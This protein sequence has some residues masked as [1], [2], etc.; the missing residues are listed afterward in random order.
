MT[1]KL[2]DLS[3]KTWNIVVQ[4][5]WKKLFYYLLLGCEYLNIVSADRLVKKQIKWDS[6]EA[7]NWQ[8]SCFPANGAAL[9]FSPLSCAFF[10][11]K[12]LC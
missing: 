12:R 6:R 1:S 4:M 2:I 7:Y 11:G 3:E 5:T 9:V 8:L 10:I